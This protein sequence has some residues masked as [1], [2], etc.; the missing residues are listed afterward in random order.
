MIYFTS[1]RHIGHNNIIN[2][3]QRPFNTIKEH[4]NAIIA[5]HNKKVSDSDTVYDLGDVGFR[6]SAWYITEC[7]R[8]M[9]GKCI[10]CLGNHEKPLRQAYKKG[11]LDDLLKNGKLE[12]IGGENA[13]YD[14]AIST[15]KMLTIENQKIFIGHYALRTWPNSFRGCIM[16]HGHSHGNLPELKKVKSFDVGVDVWD[17]APVSFDLILK[18]CKIISELKCESEFEDGNREC[19]KDIRSLNSIL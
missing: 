14:N 10:I 4:D 12:I 8:Q 13:I 16:L 5:N 11:L 3:C 1:D 17:Y 7:I 15:Y 6:C 9:N 2:M 19:I 18:K